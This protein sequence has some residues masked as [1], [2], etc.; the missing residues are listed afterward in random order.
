LL[1]A[2]PALRVVL[3]DASYPGA[4]A[5]GRNGGWLS[6]LMPGNR[7]RLAAGPGGRDGVVATQHQLIEAVDAVVQVCQQ[8]GIDADVVKGGTVAVATNR[9][10][11]G[12]L[13][14]AVQDDHHWGLTESDVCLRDGAPGLHISG[15]VG[16]SFSPHCA[17]IQPAK[18]VTGLA[19]AVTR[20]GAVIYGESPAV[21]HS[22]GV[23]RT[24]RGAVRAPWI[25][26]ATEGYTASLPG[27]RRAV[28][29][30]NSS[31]IVTSP[32]PASA[33]EQIGWDGCETLRDGAH[34]YVY[35]QRTAEGRIAIGG[36]GRPYRF[37]SRLADV[38]STPTS[39]VASL[40]AALCRL[41]P[42]VSSAGVRVDAAWSGVL[43]VTRDW[44]PS[45][46]I[47]PSGRGGLAW[48][49]GYA[50]DG[51][52]TSY[53]GGSTVADLILGR[54]TERTVLPWVGHHSR[55]WEP[56]P[57]RWLGVRAVYGLYRAADRAEARH[58]D[59]PDTSPW[60]GLAGLLAGRH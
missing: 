50:G 2:E 44:C 13:E 45:I 58:P 3:V 33:W 47:A 16:T 29:P 20:R 7:A 37:G 17:R 54:S 26:R 34:A 5:S 43:G 18:L 59:R 1:G 6:A 21:E 23:V 36:R 41:F 31:M 12:R 60:A 24:R 46:G 56:E 42:A 57:L 4:G 55:R 8:E 15:A 19:S 22:G 25:V 9:A 11:L 40:W 39:T 49:G 51:V 48:S 14:A 35:L 32:L 38:G 52:A 30:M 53:L 27:L 10:Q 28:L